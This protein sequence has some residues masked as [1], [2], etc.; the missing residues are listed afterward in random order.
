[1]FAVID[2]TKQFSS[3]ESSVYLQYFGFEDTVYNHMKYLI[4]SK[5]GEDFADSNLN[6]RR[7]SVVCI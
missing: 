2:P 1:M 5:N 7:Y 3:K 6:I 4:K